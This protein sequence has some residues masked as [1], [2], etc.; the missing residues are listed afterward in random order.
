MFQ[1]RQDGS[2]NFFRLFAEYQ[3]GFG[4][5]EGEFWLG[6][7]KLHRLTSQT[8]YE[9]RVDLEDFEGGSAYQVYRTFN[10]GDV[11]SNYRL[12]VSSSTG[13]AG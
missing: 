6:N 11:D 7:D 2:V 3:E 13:T 10:I 4:N 1:R 9:L 12:S 5:L 8:N